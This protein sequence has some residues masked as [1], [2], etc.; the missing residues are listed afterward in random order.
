MYWQGLR[1]NNPA[2]GFAGAGLFSA[3]ALSRAILG[4]RGSRR[5]SIPSRLRL[6]GLGTTR[7]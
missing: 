7:T 3:D 2:S 6:Q 5:I 1:F 4:E